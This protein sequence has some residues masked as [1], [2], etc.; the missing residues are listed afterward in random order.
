MDT[1][2][3]LL[4]IIDLL[5]FY[6]SDMIWNLYLIACFSVTKVCSNALIQ[7]KKPK[8]MLT[9]FFWYICRCY[10]LHKD[11]LCWYFLPKHWII[12]SSV[13]FSLIQRLAFISLMCLIYDKNSWYAFWMMSTAQSDSWWF[14]AY[15]MQKKIIIFGLQ[16]LLMWI[17]ELLQ[18]IVIFDAWVVPINHKYLLIPTVY[19][20]V[21]LDLSSA[22][23]SI[24]LQ[25]LSTKR[26]FMGH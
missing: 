15:F 9:T 7:I 3:V 19:T 21:A 18:V 6:F 24:P 14:H 2:A 10:Y 20:C 13:G 25:I 16:V 26:P 23:E 11:V 22:I 8:Q 1:N 12:A 17:T 5:L 4:H